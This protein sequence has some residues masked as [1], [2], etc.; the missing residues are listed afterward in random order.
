[1]AAT[2]ETVKKLIALGAGVAI[3]SGAGAGANISD[4]SFAAAGAQVADLRHRYLAGADVLCTLQGVEPDRLQG[5]NAGAR[6][7]G[8]LDPLGSAAA[9]GRLRGGRHRGPRHGMDPAHHARPVD[10]CAFFPGEPLGL[11]GRDRFRRRL[12]ARVSAHDDRRRHRARRARVRDGSRRRGPAGH[13]HRQAPRR[14]GLGDRRAGRHAGADRITGRQGHLRREGGGHLGRGGGRLC[15]GDVAGIPGRAGGAGVGA[16]GQAGHRHHHRPDSRPR[17]A[18]AHHRCADRHHEAGQRDLRPG[19]GTG[20]Q[21]RRLAARH[22][23]A[24]PW[25]D[26]AWVTPT[27]RRTWPR[28]P[29]RCMRATST[30]SSPRTGTRSGSALELPDDD[31]IVQGVRLTR[32][33]SVIHPRLAQEK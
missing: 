33:G 18:A 27:R 12:R 3:E 28:R 1:M 24:P 14:A 31:E 15:H 4:E 16:P 22:A 19:R 25:R 30:T 17:G 11:Q 10:G 7:L 8:L 32:A 29:R 13:R 26:A 5:V 23:G 21:C 2:P 20:R 6:L 9:G